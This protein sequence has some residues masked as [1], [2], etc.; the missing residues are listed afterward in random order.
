MEG[1]AGSEDGGGRDD[2]GARWWCKSEK[3]CVELLCVIS[4]W[5]RHIP[6]KE[7]LQG[8]GQIVDRHA[9]PN[10]LFEKWA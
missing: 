7:G 6:E 5:T 8:L 9:F 10:R 3:L 2:D 1:M 4:N